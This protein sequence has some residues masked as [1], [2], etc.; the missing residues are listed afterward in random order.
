MI[1]EQVE[2]IRAAAN[3]SLAHQIK[4]LSLEFASLKQVHV[5]ERCSYDWVV[6][7]SLAKILHRCLCAWRNRLSQKRQ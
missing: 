7:Y 2:T 4:Q 1:E 5:S 3:R 6:D